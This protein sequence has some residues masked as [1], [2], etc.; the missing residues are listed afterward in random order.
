M[1]QNFDDKGG[2]YS[3][4]FLMDQVPSTGIS[5]YVPVTDNCDLENKKGFSF[6]FPLIIVLARIRIKLNLIDKF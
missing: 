4:H 5:I 1:F 3:S 6:V 2:P